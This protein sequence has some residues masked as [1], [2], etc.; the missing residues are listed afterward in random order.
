M[1]RLYQVIPPP[2]ADEDGP[3]GLLD[4]VSVQI[5]KRFH[6]SMLEVYDPLAVN[7]DGNCLYRV[8]SMAMYGTQDHHLYLRIL[9]AIEL[10]T[11]QKH[12]DVSSVDINT[13]LRNVQPSPFDSLLHDALTPGAYAELAHIYALSAALDIVIESYMPSSLTS[14]VNPYSRIIVG[15]GVRDTKSPR[16]SLMWTMLS[17]PKRIADF[18]PNHFVLLA[19]KQCE[20]YVSVASD[21]EDDVTPATPA[22]DSHTDKTAS[23]SPTSVR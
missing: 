4:N 12:Y 1:L 6:G 11:H 7:G 2:P 16:C 8:V 9:T 14:A 10:I 21:T 23:A 13:H 15:R 22:D 19:R 5:L 20:S 3:F 18:Q 17:V